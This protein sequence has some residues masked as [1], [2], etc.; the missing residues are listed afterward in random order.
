MNYCAM[1]ACGTPLV[2][3]DGHIMCSRCRR[4]ADYLCSG[5]SIDDVAIIDPEDVDVAQEIVD[6]MQVG[7]T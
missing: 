2:G 5:L 7:T 4:V 3:D 1:K 6:L